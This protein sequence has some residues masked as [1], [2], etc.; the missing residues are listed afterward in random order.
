M[1]CQSLLKSF[2]TTCLHI[3]S[4]TPT[5]RHWAG[6][7]LAFWSVHAPS[8]SHKPAF[9]HHPS[10]CIF[11]ILNDVHIF[12]QIWRHLIA[13]SHRQHGQDKTRL[14]CL[15]PVGGEQAIRLLPLRRTDVIT[16]KSLQYVKAFSIG[17]PKPSICWSWPIIWKK[18]FKIL[19]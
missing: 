7:A 5:H 16:G 19:S 10:R 11:I 3:Y 15:V 18:K 2:T 17:L 4:N 9:N 1:F 14:S 13:C 8:H 6:D 12:R